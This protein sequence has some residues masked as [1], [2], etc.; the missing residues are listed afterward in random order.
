[1]PNLSRSRIA[2]SYHCARDPRAFLRENR[3]GELPLTVG[4]FGFCARRVFG[5]QRSKRDSS[6]RLITRQRQPREALLERA[7]QEARALGQI[8]DRLAGFVEDTD[9]RRSMISPVVVSSSQ[10]NGSPWVR[11][12]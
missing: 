4:S 5:K 1:M 9:M 2:G 12:T 3:A 6:C 7:E 10:R 11:Q 8:F